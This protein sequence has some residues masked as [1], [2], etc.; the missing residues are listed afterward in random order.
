MKRNEEVLAKS[1]EALRK[2]GEK[3]DH[4]PAPQLRTVSRWQSKT[5]GPEEQEAGITLTAIASKIY[6]SLL[7]NHIQSPIEPI[8]RKNQHAA[9][10]PMSFV[11]IVM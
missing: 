7:R 8:L 10:S 6:K 11:H 3:T 4:G 1:E 2:L 9:A 5:P